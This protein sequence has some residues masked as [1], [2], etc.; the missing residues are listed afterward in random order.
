MG[1]PQ[2]LREMSI[3]MGCPYLAGVGKARFD[4][5]TQKSL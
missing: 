3:I 5:M 1:F 2:G 4:C